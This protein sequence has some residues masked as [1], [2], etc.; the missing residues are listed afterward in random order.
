MSDHDDFDALFRA[1]YP[2]LVRELRLVCGGV[3]LAEEVAAEAFVACWSRWSE[4]STYDRPGAWV[5]R[6]ALRQ[7]GRRRWR[8]ARR[9]DLERIAAS[10]ASTDGPLD[11]DLLEALRDLT[12]PQRVAV[13][14]HHL[15]G[16]PADD[17]AEVLGCAEATVRS[18][19][20]RGRQRLQRAL[21]TA[22]DLQEV[23]HAHPR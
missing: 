15:A 16:W 8:R 20:R 2:A 1:E 12:H 6:V 13:V 10:W 18:H 14:L 23:P 22:D 9:G 5:R 17:I 4:V 3:P 21:G 7:A 19:L 11:L